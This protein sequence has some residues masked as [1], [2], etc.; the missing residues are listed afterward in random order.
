MTQLGIFEVAYHQGNQLLITE[1]GKA[2]LAGREKI[3]LARPTELKAKLKPKKKAEKFAKTTLADVDKSLF[4]ELRSLRRDIA[5]ASG[6]P[7]YVVFSDASLQ[8]MAH[9]QPT[10][11]EAFS[12]INGVGEVKLQKFGPKFMS[13]IQNYVS[14]TA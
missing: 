9:H 5:K 3:E 13:L 1:S 7:P 2:V 8:E 10:T 14:Q 11:R 12:K 4:Q 6:V